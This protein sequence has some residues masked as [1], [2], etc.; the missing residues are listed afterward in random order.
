[1]MCMLTEPR[2]SYY[3]V[4]SQFTHAVGHS[5]VQKSVVLYVKPGRNIGDL[6]PK[7]CLSDVRSRQTL[8]SCESPQPRTKAL[9]TVTLSIIVPLSPSLTPSPL[10]QRLRTLRGLYVVYYC[11]SNILNILH[12]QHPTDHRCPDRLCKD[13][14]NRPFQ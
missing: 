11:A 5:Y 14:R 10:N 12:S 6:M 9:R 2:T 3:N 8:A 1:M 7:S 4:K 13:N